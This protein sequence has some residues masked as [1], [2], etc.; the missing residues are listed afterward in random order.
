M[1][2]TA[3]APE[4]GI[5]QK[6]WV[7]VMPEIYQM[8]YASEE[9]YAPY[10]V[11]YAAKGTDL[12]LLPHSG[13]RVQSWKCLPLELRDGAFADY[14]ANNVGG[15]LCSEAL[16]DIIEHNRSPKDE[17][18]WLET[19]VSIVDG[20]SR[21]YY[22]LHFPQDYPVVN[23]NESLMHMGTVIRPVFTAE[24]IQGHEVFALPGEPGIRTFVSARLKTL[25]QR[26]KM[27]SVAFTKAR[28]A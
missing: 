28:V 5:T 22:F 9:A 6:G 27:T 1:G 10:G 19:T 13:A 11:A 18:Q 15:R 7:A 8:T 24:G 20:E 16:Y 4:S 2:E 3:C 23:E 26:S 14:L 25:I 21:R 17:L 12:F